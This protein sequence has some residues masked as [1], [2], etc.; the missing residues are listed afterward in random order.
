MYGKMRAGQ[1]LDILWQFLHATQRYSMGY[2]VLAV[3]MLR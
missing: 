3:Q 1:T 2:L